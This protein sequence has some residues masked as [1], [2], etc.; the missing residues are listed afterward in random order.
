MTRCHFIPQLATLAGICL[1]L[2]LHAIPAPSDLRVGEGFVDPIGFHDP[3]PTL[4][5]KLPVA[6]GVKSQSAYRIVAASHPGLLPDEADLWDSGKV[7]SDESAWVR[8]AGKPLASRLAVHWQVMFWDQDGNAAPWSAPARFE[9]GLLDK[10]DW[11]GQWICLDP[12][13]GKQNPQSPA[14]SI[15]IEKADYGEQG[16]PEHLADVSELLKQRL[17]QGNPVI[18]ANNDLAGRDP[19]FGVP[20]TLSLVIIRN[21]KREETV[22]PEDAKYNL[23][24]GTI[25]SEAA[26]FVPQHLR[27][28]FVVGKPLRS[29]RLHVTARGVF[30]VR[31]NGSKVGNDFMAPGWTPYTRKIETLTYD[32]TRQLREGSN[33]IGAILGEGW[34]AGRLGWEKSKIP[35]VESPISSSNSNSPT[36]TAPPPPSPP[37]RTGRPPTRAPS[38]SPAFT[39]VK[40]MTPARTSATGIR[41]VSTIP[42]GNRLP[43]KNP[44]P[45]SRS[46]P[47]ATIRC[48]SPNKSRPSQS[49][50]RSPDASSSTSAKTSSA[51]RF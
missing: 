20:K 14:A 37:T 34:Y 1:A 32:V 27:R 23:V 28:E 21:G 11:Q 45:T 13:A 43:P 6:A 15:V 16:K 25:L 8:Y 12:A 29:A 22:V 7:T 44:R 46:P 39:T 50:S 18:T 4:S 3:S 48:A 38:A 35:M 51:G 2:P 47:S 36:P 17:A 24:T 31:L 33:A 10:S 9:L 49:P 19:I 42:S 26:H 5:W 41:W 40:I 30:E